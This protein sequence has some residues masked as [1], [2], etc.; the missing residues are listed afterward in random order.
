MAK[1]I[2]VYRMVILILC[3]IGSVFVA[4]GVWW[5]SGIQRINMKYVST[6]AKIE[7]IEKH[8]ERYRTKTSTHYR[9]FVSYL[10]NDKVYTN[11]L[12]AYSSFMNEGDSIQI[13]YNPK[14]V[15]EIRSIDVEY[16]I[17]IVFIVVGGVLLISAM[18]MP[19]LFRR[20]NRQTD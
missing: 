13:Q 9:V 2:L 8:T 1:K 19:R 20:L 6:K 18:F 17:S 10:A 5:M 7:K 4:G 11:E 3:L 12:G 14:E 15:T 16:I